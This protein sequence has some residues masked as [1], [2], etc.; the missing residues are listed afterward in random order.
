MQGTAREP[1]PNLW[2]HSPSPGELRVGQNPR[3]TGSE[4]KSAVGQAWR[5]EHED[6][7]DCSL[8]LRA[9][10]V[11]RARF[12]TCLG[13]INT[14]FFPTSPLSNRNTY[15]MPLSHLDF[16][17]QVVCSSLQAQSGR[18]V[19]REESSVG[20]HVYLMQMVITSNFGISLWSRC[21]NELPCRD[22]GWN[23]RTGHL[24]ST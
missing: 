4:S 20:S 6:T 16:G 17:K 5:A 13:S 24:K 11:C 10:G 3:R 1:A 12:W 15:P 22:T 9:H 21:Q 18:T 19:P 14:S 2:A 8:A 7:D 23:A